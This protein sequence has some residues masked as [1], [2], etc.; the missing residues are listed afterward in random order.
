MVDRYENFFSAVLHALRSQGDSIEGRSSSFKKL[1][2]RKFM[3]YSRME[4]WM[5]KNRDG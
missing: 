2:S 1:E 5:G 3:I 4:L